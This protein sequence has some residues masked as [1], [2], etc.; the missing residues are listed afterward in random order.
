MSDFE[1]A[2]HR[3]ESHDEW[4]LA[5]RDVERIWFFNAGQASRATTERE[6]ILAEAIKTH[7]E[8]YHTRDCGFTACRIACEILE[9]TK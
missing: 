4:W 9:E 8:L 5:D 2:K 7:H 1:T 6:K 3:W